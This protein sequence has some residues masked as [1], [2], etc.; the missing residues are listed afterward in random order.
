MIVALTMTDTHLPELGSNLVT[1]LS[2]LDMNN[3]SHDYDETR[4]IPLLTK[5]LQ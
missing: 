2:G 5:L 3:L 4:D 1:T